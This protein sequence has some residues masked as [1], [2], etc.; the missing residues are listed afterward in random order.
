MNNYQGKAA[1]GVRAA[2]YA[3][4]Q[5]HV[6]DDSLE[7]IRGLLG[8]SSTH[9]QWAIDL[10]TGAGFNA[11]NMA[12]LYYRTVTTDPAGPMLREVQRIGIERGLTNVALS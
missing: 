10:G 7:I 4:S 2:D 9:T 11:F 3:V 5:V 12:Q 1:F 6:S 8:A